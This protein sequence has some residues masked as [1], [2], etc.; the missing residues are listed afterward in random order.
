MDGNGNCW[1]FNGFLLAKS[2]WRQSYFKVGNGDWGHNFANLVIKPKGA[3]HQTARNTSNGAFAE[4][5][6]FVERSFSA[7]HAKSCCRAGVGW[8]GWLLTKQ[9]SRMWTV[10]DIACQKCR[11]LCVC[12]C[13]QVHAKPT[14]ACASFGF[15]NAVSAG[16]LFVWLH[17]VAHHTMQPRQ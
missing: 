14:H 12:A 17:Q 10:S 15:L 9:C 4:K 1:C 13:V 16:I 11:N 8:S 2:G 5:Q 3:C 7:L 6:M